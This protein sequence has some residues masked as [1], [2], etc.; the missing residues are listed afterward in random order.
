MADTTQIQTELP[1][2]A[3][4]AFEGA[5]LSAA[6]PAETVSP[7]G[8]NPSSNS[9]P[10]TVGAG[11]SQPADL[12]NQAADPWV[13]FGYSD[14][15]VA[16]TDFR[17]LMQRNQV[18]EAKIRQ[19]E[20]Q[21]AQWEARQ[22][23]TLEVQKQNAPK[24][25]PAQMRKME[26]M[27][28][29]PPGSKNPGWLQSLERDPQSWFKIMLAEMVRGDQDT[30]KVFG[31]IV[32]PKL[33]PYQQF[34]DGYGKN[35]QQY[36]E[37]SQQQEFQQRLVAV[38]DQQFNAWANS[39]PEFAHGTPANAAMQQHYAQ[40]SQFYDMLIANGK[41]PF[42]Y[43]APLVAQA[44]VSNAQANAANQRIQ[45]MGGQRMPAR[46]GS[47]ASVP[48]AQTQRGLQGLQAV[49]QRDGAS[50]LDMEMAKRA[51]ENQNLL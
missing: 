40:N 51:F 8:G 25:T 7:A 33:Q 42:A 32:D 26:E 50:S 20:L 35:Y 23:A 24:P 4:Q 37:Q 41:D 27:F 31:E 3:V 48:G 45:Q 29:T 39:K 34:V 46:P 36:Q 17:S 14:P 10:P 30:Q 16:A 1:P 12:N 43:H 13:E 2:E 9:S 18:A 44:A 11:Q 15:H 38:R 47:A 49:L 6:A 28:P 19:Y 22:A 5:G 21:Q